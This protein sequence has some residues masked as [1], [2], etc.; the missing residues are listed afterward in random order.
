MI[1]WSLSKSFSKENS[2]TK[3]VRISADSS[4]WRTIISKTVKKAASLSW[5]EWT[6]LFIAVKEL[7]LARIRHAI[8]PISQILQALRRPSFENVNSAVPPS[9]DVDIQR[10]AWALG[11]AS[12]RVPWRS[13]CLLQVM[14]ADRWLRRHQIVPDFNL[15]VTKDEQGQLVAHAWLE[16]KGVTVTGGDTRTFQKLIEPTHRVV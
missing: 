5:G 11:A 6:Y 14:A 9:A 7:M 3:P 4:V 1:C 2:S 12:R 15:G 10:L 16:Y 8:F 13:D